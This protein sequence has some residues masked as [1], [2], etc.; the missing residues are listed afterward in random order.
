MLTRFPNGTTTKP[1]KILRHNPDFVWPIPTP[2]A[3][4]LRIED[5]KEVKQI[6]LPTVVDPSKQKN[7]IVRRPQSFMDKAR[8]LLTPPK[9]P[10]GAIVRILDEDIELYMNQ[11]E[12][13]MDINPLLSKIQDMFPRM[14][15][16]AKERESAIF[17]IKDKKYCFPNLAQLFLKKWFAHEKVQPITFQ[18]VTLDEDITI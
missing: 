6:T 11:R 14:Y 18:L 8:E 12:L 16:Y 1:F 10:N 3:P 5:K 7:Y 9:N 13:G 2:P 15:V 17:Y 4:V